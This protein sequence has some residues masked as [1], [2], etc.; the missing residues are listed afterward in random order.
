MDVL[1]LTALAKYFPPVVVILFLPILGIYKSQH[2]NQT[3]DKDIV[4][5]FI[6]KEN[7]KKN[8]LYN[9]QLRTFLDYLGNQLGTN[10][11]DVIVV[12]PVGIKNEVTMGMCSFLEN[13]NMQT[14][15]PNPNQFMLNV[16]AVNLK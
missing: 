14:Y 10:I 15:D 16:A 4:I 1:F 7:K 11:C 9:P 8:V 3:E 13:K 6:K 2:Y 5:T 12:K